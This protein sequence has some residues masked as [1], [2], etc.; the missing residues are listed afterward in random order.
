MSNLQATALELLRTALNNPVAEFRDGQ[1][2]A[3]EQLLNPSTR[4][5]VVQR[6][7]WGKSLVYFLTTRLLRDRGMGPTLIISPLLALMRNQISAAERIGLQAGTINS[8]NQSE[9]KVI[10]KQLLSD[11]IDILLISPERLAN[12]EFREQILLPLSARIGFF[13]VDEAHC[14]SDWGHDF[15]PDYRRIVRILQALP[16]TISVLAT[17]ATA[18][19]RVIN[20]ICAQ[21]GTNLRVIRGTLMRQSLSLQNIYLPSQVERLAWLAEHLPNLPG[22]GIIYTLTVRDAEQVAEWLRTQN[23]DA[24]AYSGQLEPEQRVVLEERLLNNAIKTLVATSALGMG[25]DKPDLGFVIHYQRPGSVVHYYQQVGRAG[26]AVSQAYGILL[27]GDE[28]QEITNYFIESAFPP[29]RHVQ[30][31]LAVLNQEDGL[32]ISGLEEKLNL[33]RGQIEKVLKLLSVEEPSPVAKIGSRWYSTPINYQ[34]NHAKI[35]QLTDIRRN[36]QARMLDYLKTNSCLMMFLAQELDDNTTEE[37]GRCAVCLG[38]PLIPETYSSAKAQEAVLFL[39]RTDQIIEP[40]KK[41]ITGGLPAYAWRGDIHPHLQ[42]EVGRALSISGDAGWGNLVKQ[43]KYQD[44]YFSDE[45]VDA[46]YDLIQRWQPDPFPTW[47]TCVPSLTRP[48]LVPSFADRLARKLN[49]PFV[50][51]VKKIKQNRPQK[52]MKNSTQQAKNLDGAFAVSRW[53][54]MAGSVFL[55]D[56]MVDSGWTFTVIAALLR[57][58][59]SGKVFPLALALNS[60]SQGG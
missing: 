55:I 48:E 44:N 21:I 52:E 54:G 28:D 26:R 43:G 22:S 50:P 4:L 59:G 25:F 20:D 24:E 12:D 57:Q 8:S 60:L 7:G 18:N 13:V 35:A 15:R 1:W 5:L 42:A 34:V 33:S 3:I 27:S 23:I 10:Q 45:L 32:S 37:C 40:R 11:Q 19:D 38:K 53:Q 49:I 58:S 16:P 9:W 41:W 39:R 47:V 6:T 36:E 17:T 31:I 14:I 56:D 51:C 29:E 2:E 30:E 46:V